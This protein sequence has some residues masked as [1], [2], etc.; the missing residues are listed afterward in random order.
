MSDSKTVLIIDDSAFTRT[1]IR[2]ILE[3]AGFE[4]VAEA[5]TGEAGIDQAFEHQPY[6]IT[7]DN[8]LP[9]MTG[10]DVLDTLKQMNLPSKVIMISA[11]GQE[12]IQKIGIDKG[13]EHYLP[14]PV[15]EEE[16]VRLMNEM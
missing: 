8:I 16:L 4:V 2:D 7:L 12:E 3:D 14:K 1:H 15:D 10:F 13:A 6:F 11:V 9:D 5:I